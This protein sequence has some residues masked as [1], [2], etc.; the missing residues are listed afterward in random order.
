MK[1]NIFSIIAIALIGLMGFTSCSDVLDRPSKTEKE[2]DNYWDNEA[3]VRL[4]ANSFYDY[5]FPGYGTGWTVYYAPGVN[6]TS[7]SDDALSNS[8]QTN[9]TRQV[10]LSKGA[11]T[12]TTSNYQSEYQGPTWNFAFIRKINIMRDRLEDRMKGSL[13]DEAYNH[14]M[15]FARLFHGIEYARL[16]NVFGDVPYYEHE[17][18]NLDR[19]EVYKDRTPRD[20]V[21]DK[22]YEDFDFALNNIRKSD[23]EGN[24]NRYMAAALVC[25]YALYEGSWQKYYYNNNER[26]QKFFELAK[27]AGDVVINSG[28]YAIVTPFRDLFCSTDLTKAKD[29]LLYRKYDSSLGKTHC[30]ASYCNVNEALAQGPTAD[31]I[32]SFCC[33]DGKSYKESTVASATDFRLEKLIM[34]RDPRFEATFYDSL[35]NSSRS[36]MLYVVKF[37][38]RAALNYLSEPGGTP[39]TAWTG[40]NNTTG[41]PVLRY[42]EV[43]LNWIEAKAELETLGGAV[44]TQ[45]DIDISINAIRDRPLD[46]GQ[47]AL[48][49]QKTAHMELA[50]LSDDP[51]RDADV[52]QLLWEIRRERRMEFAFEQGRIIDLRRWHK[53]NY[54]DTT[55]NP[56]ILFGAYVD[57]SRSGKNSMLGDMKNYVG[58][59]RVQKANGEFVVYDGNNKRQV[60]GWFQA[61]TTEPRQPFLN[62]TN[63]NPYLCPIGTNQINDYQIHGYT[64]TQTPG[65]PSTNN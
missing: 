37:I 16:V 51:D 36:S 64:L 52:P 55:E 21:M 40:T 8:S 57:I 45:D 31:L 7:F 3:K 9:F 19:D 35:T 49:V 33:V 47:E 24:I 28:R 63:V 4:Y 34:T 62:I 61:E 54:M 11:I 23:G 25:R 12:T 22:V 18:S 17:L 41:F 44:V 13:S 14:W 43:L 56:D 60:K 10:P 65:W 2:D 42:S 15:G 39:A 30:V 26:A 58:K 38:P 1:R 48:G 27:T 5:F 53:L 32:K 59:L 46:A 50:T 20:E 29:V 6:N